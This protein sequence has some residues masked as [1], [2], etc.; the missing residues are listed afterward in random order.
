LDLVLIGV[1]IYLVNGILSIT[2]AMIIIDKL[3][4]SKKFS[5]ENHFHFYNDLFSWEMFY[6]FIG[7]E[8]FLK[9]VSVFLLF[10]D[11]I[12]YILLRVRILIVFFPFWTKIIHLE[13]VMDKITYERH[14]FAGIIPLII[15]LVLSFTILP[16]IILIFIFL[17]TTFCPYLFFFIFFK[18]TGTEKKKTLKI[19]FGSIIIG[20]GIVFRTEILDEYLRIA[21]ILDLLILLTNITTPLLFIIESML[22]FSSFRK[23][24]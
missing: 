5:K 18:N 22:I 9:I 24:L 20:F 3:Y 4:I 1:L 6:I 17:C 13:K 16:N 7:I 10:N 15:V 19:I 11:A 14:Y 8:S 12:T 23:E 21:E 2:L